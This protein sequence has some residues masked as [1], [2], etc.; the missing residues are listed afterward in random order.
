MIESINLGDILI[1]KDSVVQYKEND[2]VDENAISYLIKESVYNGVDPIDAS[3]G[4]KN[5]AY[6]QVQ[7]LIKKLVDLGYNNFEGTVKPDGTRELMIEHFKL[8]GQWSE[9]QSNLKKS[10]EKICAYLSNENIP[11]N[12]KDVAKD[13]PMECA[14]GCIGNIQNFMQ[15]TQINDLDSLIANRKASLVE[16]TILDNY[17]SILKSLPGVAIFEVAGADHLS[18]GHSAYAADYHLSIASEIH[19]VEGIKAL[20]A[21]ILGLKGSSDPDATRYNYSNHGKIIIDEIESL[22]ENSLTSEYLV[23]QIVDYFTMGYDLASVA[24]V[25]NMLQRMNEYGLE[26]NQSLFF[27]EDFSEVKNDIPELVKRHVVKIL[28]KKVILEIEASQITQI[29]NDIEGIWGNQNEEPEQQAQVEES[30]DEVAA[31]QAAMQRAAEMRGIIERR[32]EAARQEQIR[33]QE[34]AAMQRAAE[35]RGIIERRQEAARQEQIRLQEEA[36]ARQEELDIPEAIRLSTAIQSAPPQQQAPAP[37]QE[38]SFEGVSDLFN[39]SNVVD[40]V[41]SNA[42][43]AEEEPK[44]QE[45]APKEQVAIQDS[46]ERM[47]DMFKQAIAVEVAK[48]VSAVITAVNAV[49][50][51]IV[52]SAADSKMQDAK[53]LE[54]MKEELVQKVENKQVKADNTIVQASILNML[55]QMC[56][57]C[58]YNNAHG[59]SADNTLE[60]SQT[61]LIQES[62]R[63][64]GLAE[65]TNMLLAGHVQ[66]ALE[67]A[68]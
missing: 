35:M 24:E 66:E 53:P 39:E 13:L 28:G 15:S 5:A 64:N 47:L 12:L 59:Q 18:F 31:I 34:E 29:H 58:E 4:N 19:N 6:M 17:K 23:G 45:S 32:Q 50:N 63:D 1:N 62:C 30:D 52:L 68:A 41:S 36:A 33:L 40:V 14:A 48:G 22:Y 65:G 42:V 2:G 55:V 27:S 10:L 26:F 44:I 7:S 3:N 21:P 61:Y 46:G 57:L 8:D 37:E 9:R 56:K 67:M 60:V 16:N 54:V 43:T 25:N 11:E 38:Q 51:A 20:L 49:S